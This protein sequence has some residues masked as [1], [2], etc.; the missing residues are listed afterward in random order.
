MIVNLVCSIKYKGYSLS[1]LEVNKIINNFMKKGI[2]KG[3]SEL[4]SSTE[5]KELEN[6]SNSLKFIKGYN[7]IVFTRTYNLFKKIFKKPNFKK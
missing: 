2:V 7:E 5:I 3:K 4:L 1:M 6:L